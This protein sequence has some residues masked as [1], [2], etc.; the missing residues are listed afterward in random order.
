MTATLTTSI[1]LGADDRAVAIVHRYTPS[2]TM[3]RLGIAEA[4]DIAAL[5]IGGLTL[6]WDDPD[7]AEAFLV[8]ALESLRVE[9]ERY[10]Q[11]GAA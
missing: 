1:N 3:V 2:P 5:Y 11:A 6:Q 4:C 9:R 7:H 8:A 10:A